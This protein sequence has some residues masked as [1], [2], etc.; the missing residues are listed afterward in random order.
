MMQI[1]CERV[2]EDSGL[3]ALALTRAMRVFGGGAIDAAGA[4]IAEGG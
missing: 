4:V 1:A 2:F 3:C